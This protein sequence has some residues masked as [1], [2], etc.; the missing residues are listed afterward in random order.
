MELSRSGLVILRAATWS[1]TVMTILDGGNDANCINLYGNPD[2]KV[3]FSPCSCAWHLNLNSGLGALSLGGPAEA[4][5]EKQRQA[6]FCCK[7]NG[8]INPSSRGAGPAKHLTTVLSCSRRDSGFRIAY[9]AAWSGISS[10]YMLP[11]SQQQM[12][13]EGPRTFLCR[14]LEKLKRVFGSLL[15][16]LISLSGF[17][18]FKNLS[19]MS[20]NL[21][22]QP[23][24]P[25]FQRSYIFQQGE[26]AFLDFR[27]CSEHDQKSTLKF[28][29]RTPEEGS[30]VHMSRVNSAL[31]CV[32]PD[33]SLIFHAS[34]R[35]WSGAEERR[36]RSQGQ[37]RGSWVWRRG[38]LTWTWTVEVG[39]EKVLTQ[40][41]S[42]KGYQNST[43]FVKHEIALTLSSQQSINPT[44]QSLL[45]GT[46]FLPECFKKLTS[47]RLEQSLFLHQTM[48]PSGSFQPAVYGALV[49]WLA[50][51]AKLHYLQKLGVRGY[52]VNHP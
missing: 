45:A 11:I 6:S 37:W 42:Q 7:C 38:K 22:P 3:L 19:D 8:A 41:L 31:R 52:A 24:Q 1:F 5:A 29:N 48:G 35:Y 34:R 13:N 44:S 43:P 25:G 27:H 30:L 23:N 16:T 26:S 4:G 14:T 49:G 36:T 12:Y 9:S 51:T 10:M 39:F 17:R 20:M 32:Q 46:F 2:F 28:L 15:K 47:W 21:L 40:W 50:P 18:Y 33:K